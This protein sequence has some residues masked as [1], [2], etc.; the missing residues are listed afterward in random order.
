MKIIKQNKIHIGYT[1]LLGMVVAI[2]SFLYPYK[3]AD[4]S[5]E[6]V[7][8]VEE[9]VEQENRVRILAKAI[10]KFEGYYEGSRS[11][12]NNNSGNLRDSPFK[13]GMRAGFAYFDTYEE[14]FEALMW[15]ITISADGRSSVY[16]PSMTL[17]EFFNVYAPS[18]DSNQPNVYYARVMEETGFEEGMVM[19][20]LL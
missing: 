15:Q 18:S 17:L 13:S 6:L 10:E 11:Y 5:T 3:T 9:I 7:D 19:A 1:I 16:T 8:I 2:V 20:D 14:G 12:V 4:S